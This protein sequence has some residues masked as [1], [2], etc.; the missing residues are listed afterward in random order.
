MRTIVEENTVW[1]VLRE[2]VEQGHLF[3]ARSSFFG[4]DVNGHFGNWD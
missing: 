1:E 2:E 3:Q 4:I